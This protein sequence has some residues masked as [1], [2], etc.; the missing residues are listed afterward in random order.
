MKIFK[1]KSKI[2][3][4]LFFKS[5]SP[6]ECQMV[7]VVKQALTDRTFDMSNA[8]RCFTDRWSHWYKCFKAVRNRDAVT[9]D[10][11]IFVRRVQQHLETITTSRWTVILFDI[12]LQSSE[13]NSYNKWREALPLEF[14]KRIEIA[15][16]NNDSPIL[17]PIPTKKTIKESAL[18]RWFTSM[19]KHTQNGSWIVAHCPIFVVNGKSFLW[20]PIDLWCCKKFGNHCVFVFFSY[21]A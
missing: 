10:F 9:S 3:T 21:K 13:N 8:V 5:S 16:T 4:V 2:K 1:K 19:A 14:F 7:F 17:F 12:D 11:R 15:W 20:T 18:F 6:I